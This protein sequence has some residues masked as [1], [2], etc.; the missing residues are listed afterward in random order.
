MAAADISGF[1]G[2]VTMPTGHGGQ[3][4]GFTVRRTMNTK[5]TMRYGG[6]RFARARGG[7]I[8]ITGDINIFLRMGA[9]GMAPGI[10]TPTPDGAS[11]TLQFE[12]GCTLSGTAIF[13]DW[14]STHAFEDPAVE[15]TLSY[16]FNSVV[17]ETWAV[18]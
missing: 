10:V 15:A 3:A 7:I 18:T 9:A 14:N 13:P 5:N 1:N 6:D 8:N 17:V 2:A 16:T 12:V 4:K 11:L